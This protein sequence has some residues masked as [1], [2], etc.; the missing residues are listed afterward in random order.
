MNDTV[1]NREFDLRTILGVAQ[2]RA[3]VAKSENMIVTLK[4]EGVNRVVYAGYVSVFAFI[5]SGCV[6]TMSPD[7]VSAEDVRFK[8]F[9]GMTMAEFM[10]KTMTTPQDYYENDGQRVFIVD[11]PHMGTPYYCRMQITTVPI[12]SSSGAG[13]W[14]I[15]SIARQGGCGHV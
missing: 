3:V 15:V 4:K 12:G 9:N 5:L 1:K 7:Y 10:Q 2:Y 13:A 14:R 11:K 6:D 8:S